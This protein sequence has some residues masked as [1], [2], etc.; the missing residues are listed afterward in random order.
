MEST[1]PLPRKQEP[2]S[3]YCMA[4]ALVYDWLKVVIIITPMT[5]LG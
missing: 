5:D 3:Y 1:P 4:E 2:P